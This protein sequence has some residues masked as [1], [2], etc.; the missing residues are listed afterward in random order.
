MKYYPITYTGPNTTKAF[1]VTVQQ[2]QL[3]ASE[4]REAFIHLDLMARAVPQ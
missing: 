3:A 4:V 2:Q 1:L